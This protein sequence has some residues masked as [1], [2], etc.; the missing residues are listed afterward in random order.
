MSAAFFYL[1]QSPISY[2]RLATEI[3][4][5]FPSAEDIRTG[6]RLSSCLYLR[7]CID[8][9]L[10]MTPP[11]SGTLWRDSPVETVVDGC[12]I[13]PGTQVGVNTY[14]L[15]HNEQLFPNSFEYRPERFLSGDKSRPG[16]SDEAVMHTRQGFAPFS[17]GSRGCVGK[18]MAYTEISLTLAKTLWHFD[19]KRAEGPLRA[20][21][22]GDS[23]HKDGRTRFN[24]F[25][26][27]EHISASHDGPYLVFSR[28][29]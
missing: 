22:G 23:S 11:A 28:R 9:A 14:A 17:I 10:R 16:S 1:S 3:R 8:E 7:A 26:I 2:A 6:P 4:S 15:H 18:S 24:E 29:A 20:I 5:T 21:G 13:P 12:I 25:Q 19:F 27:Q